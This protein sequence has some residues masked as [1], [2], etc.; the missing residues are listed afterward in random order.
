MPILHAL[1]CRNWHTGWVLTVLQLRL[2]APA[3]THNFQNS[4][5]PPGLSMPGS[6]RW[7]PEL[8]PPV[9]VFSAALGASMDAEQPVSTLVT[10][11]WTRMSRP[12]SAFYVRVT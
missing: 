2:C 7:L 9:K 12:F 6:L 8:P 1:A 5:R 11:A 4:S 3:G 10:P